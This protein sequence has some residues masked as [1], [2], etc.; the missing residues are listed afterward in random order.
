VS[1]KVNNYIVMYSRS[2]W[3]IIMGSGLDDLIYWYFFTITV[4][5]NNLDQWLST[6][7]CIPYW[8]ASVCSST[9]TNNEGRITVHTWNFFWILLRMN[10]DSC[11]MN[12]LLF[13]LMC[14]PFLTSG[15][16]NEGHH[17]EQLV[18]ILPLS[19]ECVFFNIRCR[20]NVCLSV[21]TLWPSAAYPL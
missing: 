12:A 10:Y 15:E 9:A 21:A 7:G 1:K 4:N 19:R 8:T 2:A 20:G 13:I 11:L 6:T 17:V 16:P 18:V 5:Y 3:L 14:P